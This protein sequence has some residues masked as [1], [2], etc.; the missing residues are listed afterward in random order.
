M[1]ESGGVIDVTGVRV[2]SVKVGYVESRRARIG[3]IRRA[4]GHQQG[5]L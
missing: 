4:T 1:V 2:S 5:R 3:C